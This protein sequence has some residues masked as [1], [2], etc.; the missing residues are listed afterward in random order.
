L[1]SKYVSVSGNNI[2]AKPL[3]ENSY[4]LEKRKLNIEIS[5]TYRGEIRSPI[6][7]RTEG[8][9]LEPKQTTIKNR[10]SSLVNVCS[11]KHKRI[12]MDMREGLKN[13]L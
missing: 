4:L 7:S 11:F 5:L 3:A 6:V 8:K 9:N 12:V 10:S 13:G 1:G 2:A